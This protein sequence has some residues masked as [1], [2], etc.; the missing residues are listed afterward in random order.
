MRSIGVDLDLR[1]SHLPASDGDAA[2]IVVGH[3]PSRHVQSDKLHHIGR[4]GRV[5]AEH[6]TC[7]RRARLRIQDHT[8]WH[9]RL[10][11]DGTSDFQLGGQRV[12]SRCDDDVAH[13]RVGELADQVRNVAD[14][15][16]RRRLQHAAVLHR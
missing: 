2:S 7:A 12:V 1:Q 11:G 13:R 6:T 16:L 9:R 10:D 4:R 8:T 3:I 5:D 15:G 14:R